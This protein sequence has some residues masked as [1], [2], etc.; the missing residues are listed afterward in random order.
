MENLT[1]MNIF[2]F[3]SEPY[4]KYVV[5]MSVVALQINNNFIIP[6]WGLSM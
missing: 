6:K 1:N 5:K 4:L 2:L 3:N